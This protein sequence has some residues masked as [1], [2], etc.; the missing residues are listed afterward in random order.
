M[1][2]VL[3]CEMKFGSECL[4]L[5]SDAIFYFFICAMYISDLL[6]WSLACGPLAA[7]A[8]VTNRA[9]NGSSTASLRAT[10]KD[11][12]PQNASDPVGRQQVMFVD[13]TPSSQHSTS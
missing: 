5:S 9:A 2:V 4:H 1:V 10:P 12:I 7:A 3:A 11:T 6:S 8:A 13:H